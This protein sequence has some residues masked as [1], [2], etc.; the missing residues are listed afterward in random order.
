VSA[1]AASA[2]EVDRRTHRFGL[3]PVE[4]RRSAGQRQFAGAGAKTTQIYEGTNQVQRIVMG[5]QLLAGAQ[6]QL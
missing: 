6:S 2:R 3:C 1:R 4:G 5:R